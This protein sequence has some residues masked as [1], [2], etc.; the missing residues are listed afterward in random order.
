MVAGIF[1]YLLHGNSA[2]VVLTRFIFC[3]VKG[4]ANPDLFLTEA[5]RAVYLYRHVA[6]RVSFDSAVT[7][8]DRTGDSDVEYH[9]LLIRKVP[10]GTLR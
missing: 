8:A 3:F 6:A 5:L 7:V 1:I 2:G 10:S 9:V 4:F